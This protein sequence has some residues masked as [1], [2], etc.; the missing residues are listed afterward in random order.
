M[1]LTLIKNFRV[2]NKSIKSVLIV[3]EVGSECIKYCIPDFTSY[4]VIPTRNI[5]PV[6]LSINF[7]A[8]LVVR[9]I[10]KD[11]IRLS[12]LYSIIDVLEPKV[13]ISF[14]DNAPKMGKIQSTFPDKLVISVQNG[15]RTKLHK[16]PASVPCLYGFG[17]YEKLLLSDIGSS[18]KEYKAVGSLRFGIFFEK[19]NAMVINKYDVCYISQFSYHSDAFS[20]HL[21]RK[22]FDRLI[23]I[24]LENKY[25]LSVAL[26][27]SE[28][29]TGYSLELEH[30]HKL[31]LNNYAVYVHNNAREFS[32]YA[33]GL[34]SSVIASF[35]STLAYELFGAGKKVLFLGSGSQ[36][37]IK[38][39]GT[40][41]IFS[42]MPD[43]V[44]LDN[45][46]EKCIKNKLSELMVMSE[47]KYLS[48]IRDAQ[49]YYMNSKKGHP[50]KIIK[51]RISDFIEI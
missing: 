29:N 37:L 38:H 49:M 31:D 22:Y 27:F 16:F 28:N 4:V 14:I 42:R 48:A 19:Q 46:S 6:V 44:R 39:H 34:S 9:I 2:I 30:F 40:E 1:L 45:L 41:D 35:S 21:E 50:H 11:G 25:S 8:R 33:L 3:D 47:T 7:F 24:C 23:N 10:R 5:I 36:E 26:R 15:L 13:I 20:V 12:V 17:Y 43:E 32:S 18:I 51:K